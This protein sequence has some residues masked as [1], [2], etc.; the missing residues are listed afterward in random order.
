MKKISNFLARTSTSILVTA[1]YILFFICLF[2]ALIFPGKAGDGSMLIMVSLALFF[3]GA[4]GIPMI[5]RKEAQPFLE[6][7]GWAVVLGMVH[8]F[9]DWSLCISVIIYLAQDKI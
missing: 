2:L 1:H 9:I 4:A 8:I 3:W 6:R 5:I 7:E